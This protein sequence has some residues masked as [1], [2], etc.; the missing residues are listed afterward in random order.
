MLA[1]GF[2]ATYRSASPR[3]SNTQKPTSQAMISATTTEDPLSLYPPL[4]LPGDPGARL[5]GGDETDCI[6]RCTPPGGGPGPKGEASPARRV[7]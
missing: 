4:T 2:F 3:A 5:V 6:L 1:F 7:V